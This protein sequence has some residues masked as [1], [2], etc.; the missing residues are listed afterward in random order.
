MF[1]VDW[2]KTSI[3]YQLPEGMLEK[4]VRVAYPDTKLI[5]HALIAGGCANLNIKIQL[6][7]E[8]HPL[9]LR[10]YLRH[11]NAA[12]REQKLGTLLVL[13]LV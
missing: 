7:N 11:N 8:N 3:T 9:I 6:E 4:M 5:S 10:I 2:G 12:Y 1:K 13:Y